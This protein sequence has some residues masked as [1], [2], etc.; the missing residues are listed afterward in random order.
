MFYILSECSDLVGYIDSDWV[1]SIDDRNSTS[2]Y[3]FHIG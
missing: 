1:G 2:G 3:V